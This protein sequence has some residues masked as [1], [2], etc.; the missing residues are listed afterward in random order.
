MTFTKTTV[1]LFVCSLALCNSLLAEQEEVQTRITHSIIPSFERFHGDGQA[2]VLGGCVLL[3]E[4]NCLSCHKA[5]NLKTVVSTKTAPNLDQ[6]GRRVQPNYLRKFL[7]DPHGTKPGT[8]M[9]AVFAGLDEKQRAEK[10]EALTHFLASTGDLAN[11]TPDKAQAGNGEQ[12]F[13]LVGCTA[14]HSPRRKDKAVLRT[15]APL[16]ELQKKYSY[17]GLVDFLKD[18]HKTRPAGRMPNLNLNDKDSRAIASY[19]MQGVEFAPNMKFKYYEGNWQ[20]L[21]NFAELKPKTEGESS[22]FDLNVAPRKNSMGLVYNGFI[23]I[24]KDGKYRFF[25]GSDDGSRLLIDGKEV[26]NVDGV[27]PYQE[28]NAEVDL[29]AGAHAIQVE[30]FQGGGEWILKLDVQAPGFR[31]QAAAGLISMTEEAPKPRAVD[32]EEPFVLNDELIPVGKQV[33]TEAGCA[34]CHSMKVDN[35]QIASTAKAKPF[36]ELSKADGGCLATA[37]VSGVPGYTLSQPQR[38]ALAAVVAAEELPELEDAERIV[39]TM[40]TFNCFACH[41]RNKIGGPERARDEFFQTTIKEMGDEGRVPPPLDGVGDKLRED[42]FKNVMNNG[43]NGRPY[44]QTKMPKFGMDNIGHLIPAFAKVD[45]REEGG[46]PD[47]E[48]PIHRVKTAGRQLVGDKK[49]ACIKCHNF[50]KHKATGIQALDL[51]TMTKRLRHD[52]F[53]RYM[54]NPQKYRPGTRMPAPWPFGVAMI[55][56]ILDGDVGKQR[57]AVWKYLEDGGKAG[58]PLGIIRQAIVLTPTDKPIIYRNF[59]EGLSARGIGVGYPEKANIA[60]DA[61]RIELKLIWHGQFIDA[62]KHWIGRGPGYQAPLGD[63]LMRLESGVPFA[64]LENEDSAWPNAPAREQGYKFTGYR[65]NEKHQ[66]IFRYR[67]GDTLVEDAIVPVKHVDDL[68]SLSRRLSIRSSPERSTIYYRAAAGKKIE[69]SGD[70]WFTLD[71]AVR[72]HVE[73]PAGKPVLRQ[74]SGRF[75]LLLPLKGGGPSEVTQKYVW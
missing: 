43:A 75:E 36:A 27:H 12:L 44:M 28:K 1:S 33:F 69:D 55:K 57:E 8:T 31:R 23:H 66:P 20:K 53:Y 71:E 72:V 2:S 38:D 34:S 64:L 40:T 3:G 60:F 35:K 45:L 59:I 26:V 73:S 14:C 22:G 74:D 56:D 16:G 37:P 6:I 62:G 30:F 7:A 21:P 52:W 63:N 51:T 42:W 70:G 58:I 9:P 4:L 13:H 65:L 49:L 10:V 11:Q 25:L 15:S 29:K 48:T 17:L 39:Q 24:K 61:E 47:L 46:M 19:F 32:G 67:F 18:P 5:D 68:P 54:L 41:A 50:G